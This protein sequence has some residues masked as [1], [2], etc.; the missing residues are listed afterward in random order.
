[1]SPEVEDELDREEE[2]ELELLFPRGTTRK[3]VAPFGSRALTTK[4]LDIASQRDELERLEPLIELDVPK[5]SRLPKGLVLLDHMHIPKTPDPK[6]PGTFGVGP[7]SVLKTGDMNP[8]FIDATDNLV[9]DT[10]GVGLQNCLR[11]LMTKRFQDLLGN[12]RQTAP[13]AYD[14]VRIALVDLTGTKLTAPE[15]AGW[16][17]SVALYGASVPKILALYAAHQLRSDL[18]HLSTQRKFSSGTDLE[19]A[20]TAEWNQKGVKRQLP[21]LV[22]LFDIHRWNT[23]DPLDFTPNAKSAF[24][25]IMHNCPAGTL[26]AKVGFPFIGSVTWQSGLYHPQRGG[27]WLKSAY[28]D[29]GSWVDEPVHPPHSHNATAL[30]A[31]T[32]FALVAQGRLVDD[33][34]SSAIQMALRNGCVTSLFPSLPVVASK[35]GIVSRHVHDCALIRD[36]KVQYAL[37][38]LSTVSTRRQAELYTRLC[39]ELDGLIRKNNQIPKTCP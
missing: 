22:W 13:G 21:D 36:D 33:N 35:C 3:L 14:R 11:T 7:L 31:A 4:W 5:A 2:V 25:E 28:C 1:M 6:A 10:S 26:I 15:F 18:R 20:A 37:A 9:V 23:T 17:S 38:V 12:R 16:G 27:L 32:Y 24:A 34:S 30:A 19:Q 39:T 8:G 29:K